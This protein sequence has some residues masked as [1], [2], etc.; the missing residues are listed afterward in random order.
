LLYR[1]RFV[2]QP[3]GLG[4]RLSQFRPQ[5]LQLSFEWLARIFRRPRG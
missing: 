5:L 2:V 4:A 1:R 3:M